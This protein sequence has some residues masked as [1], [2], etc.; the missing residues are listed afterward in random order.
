[1]IRDHYHGHLDA[2]AIQAFLEG[3]LPKREHTVA[4]EHLAGCARCT[5]EVQAW[6]LVFSELSDLTPLGPSKDFASRVMSEVHVPQPV[7]LAAR[8]RQALTGWGRVPALH[9]HV[10]GEVLQAMADGT[11][12]ARKA[13]RIRTH[14]DGCQ[15]CAGE[16]A[17]W[18]RLVDSLGRMAHLAPADGFAGRVMSRVH[19]P[20]AQ[21]TVSPVREAVAGTRRALAWA[22]RAVPTSRHAWATLSGIAV[23]PM[24]TVGLVLY[25]LLSHPTL[26]AGSLLSFAGWKVSEFSG[27]AWSAISSMLMESAGLFQAYTLMESLAAAPA[28]LAAGV[29]T[30]STMMVAATWILY[31]NLIATRTV[32]GRYARVSA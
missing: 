22:A 12:P 15:Q 21:P 1:M 27:L 20:V 8:V 13:A 14:L 7:P 26:T 30:L 3:E 32:D 24:A 9:G 5:S 23:A 19:V 11:L 29:V 31:R 4:E 2:E 17:T 18:G 10:P 6:R 25:T 28:L 16:L